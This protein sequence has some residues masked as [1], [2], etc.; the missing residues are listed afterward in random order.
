MVS[1]EFRTLVNVY[2]KI[3]GPKNIFKE[4]GI[5]NLL[6]H[7]NKIL[8]ANAAEG[9]ILEGKSTE[10]GVDAEL[11]VKKDAKVK[12]PVH[13]CFGILP[14][15]G[16]QE[17]RIN[18]TVED[19]GEVDVIA[20]CIFPNAVKVIH[21]MDAQIKIGANAKFKY[22]EIHYHGNFGG[23][24]VIP[25]AKVSVGKNSVYE[26]IFALLQGR[27][28]FLDFNYGVDCDEKSITDMVVKVYG[29]GAD[30]I[31]VIEKVN[32]NGEG[33]RSLIK[34][35]AVLIDK[36]KAEVIGETYGNAPLARG[37]VDCIEILNGR[38]AIGKA[39]PLV[40]VRDERA[41]VTHEAAIGSV[42]KK[43]LETLMA[44]GLDQQE[45]IDVIV[46]GILR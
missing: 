43:Q 28:G 2:E 22:Q 35:R 14:K 21:K 8:N 24:R 46:K 19:D 7:E 45:A 36:A 9:V 5:A 29:K 16:R 15:E 20:H 12:D 27:V 40:C 31:K 26:N 13:L 3:G 37:H 11:L 23:T 44:R 42:D 17:I 6:V 32:L 33:A 41:K 39:I 18:V 1:N 25:R 10:S 38:K 30:E 4:K 34:T